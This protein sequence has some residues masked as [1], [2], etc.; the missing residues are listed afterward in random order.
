VVH[1]LVEANA[2]IEAAD[3]KGMTALTHASAENHP[4]VCTLL[5][6]KGALVDAIDIHGATAAWHAC[7]QDSPYAL[8]VL[9]GHGADLAVAERRFQ[10]TPVDVALA[11]GSSGCIRV[12]RTIPGLELPEPREADLPHGGRA[13]GEIS[14]KKGSGFVAS[15][16]AELQRVV[17]EGGQVF[18]RRLVAHYQG[19]EAY[20][21]GVTRQWKT[22]IGRELLM[23]CDKAKDRPT[24]FVVTTTTAA[25]AVRG[26]NDSAGRPSF[27]V[28]NPDSGDVIGELVLATGVRYAFIQSQSDHASHPVLFTAGRY[29]HLMA[30][31][32]M[33]LV[34]A[35]VPMPL[36]VAFMPVAMSVMMVC[37]WHRSWRCANDTCCGVCASG[38]VCNDGV[39]VAPFVVV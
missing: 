19:E 6:D 24:T 18:P 28:T 27:V 11:C 3:A 37:Q 4:S 1:V 21:E 22:H 16:L 36:V 20:G 10:Q 26:R 12:L 15:S 14:V 29:F 30:R 32:P 39:P 8:E 34:V 5:L 35:F 23:C 38:D 25:P 17:D 13:S 7:E 33:P 9:I 31:V 2:S